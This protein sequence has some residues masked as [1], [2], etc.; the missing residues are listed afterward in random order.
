MSMNKTAIAIIA[1][2]VAATINQSAQAEPDA[3]AN[4]SVAMVGAGLPVA[5]HPIPHQPVTP[6]KPI[7]KT[8]LK[9]KARTAY[10]RNHFEKGQYLKSKGN[11]NGALVEFLRSS[12]ENPRLVRAFYEQALIFQQKGFLKLAG[13]SLEQALAIKPDFQEARILLATIRIEQGNVG[14]AVQELSKSLGLNIGGTAGGAKTAA[15]STGV[16]QKRETNDLLAKAP[17]VLQ[18]LHSMLAEIPIVVVQPASKPAPFSAPS[19]ISTPHSQAPSD[20]SPHGSDTKTKSSA[21]ENPSEEKASS[22]EEDKNKDDDVLVLRIPKS[23]KFLWHKPQAVDAG[24]KEKSE[25]ESKDQAAKKNLEEA[26]AQQRAL[27]KKNNQS[28]N[29]LTHFLHQD[30]ADSQQPSNIVITHSDKVD[31]SSSE[32]TVNQEKKVEPEKTVEKEKPAEKTA[33]AQEA[34]AEKAALPTSEQ[35]Q[36]DHPV[37]RRPQVSLKFQPA[38]TAEA[39][40]PPIKPTF[41]APAAIAVASSALLSPLQHQ[42]E[43]PTPPAPDE[44]EWTQRLRYLEEN[45]TASLKDGEAFMFAEDTGEATLFLAN[46]QAIKRKIADSRDAQ[47]VVRQRRPDMLIPDDLVYN[48]NLLGKLVPKFDNRDAAQVQAQHDSEALSSEPAPSFNV[49]NMMGDSQG[50]WGWLKHVFKF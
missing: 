18:S 12:Q 28:H 38:N 2:A 11:T 41:Q 33:S 29:W 25:D 49:D 26:T 17:A 44:D 20:S 5:P 1:L 16:Q 24:A 35:E 15:K 47:E 13:S 4:R 22:S 43:Q 50:F 40:A 39:P 3:H 8:L 10:P 45:G 6:H 7:S 9:Q 48:L 42:L 19:K 32:K 21:E 34:R 14:G 37:T 30:E 27:L 36:E 31:D 23:L 46:G